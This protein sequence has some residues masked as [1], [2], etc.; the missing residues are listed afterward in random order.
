MN[1]SVTKIVIAAGLMLGSVS[2]FAQ[3]PALQ[4]ISR[5]SSV[6]TKTLGLPQGAS[7][8]QILA[9]IGSMSASEQAAFSSAMSLLNA[10]LK[11]ETGSVQQ[12]ASNKAANDAAVARIFT[13]NNE[14]MKMASL[15]EKYGSRDATNKALAPYGACTLVVSLSRCLQEQSF[16]SMKPRTSLPLVTS[17]RVTA[18]SPLSRLKL[19]QFCSRPLL[20]PSDTLV[21]FSVKELTK[22]MINQIQVTTSLLRV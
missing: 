7:Q 2:A 12:V 19:R 6:V 3:S 8:A 1:N 10:S 14:P 17:T 18:T 13:V 16:R 21:E 9:K 20:T 11:P 5:N 15:A 4:A 22:P